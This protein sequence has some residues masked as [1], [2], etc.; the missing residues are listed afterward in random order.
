MLLETIEGIAAALEADP[1]ELLKAAGRVAGGD[2]F[3]TQVLE[4]LDELRREVREVKETIKRPKSEAARP[5][6][7]KRFGPHRHSPA[8]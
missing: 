5:C 3:E 7:S 1:K 6:R 2:N 8:V 4:E